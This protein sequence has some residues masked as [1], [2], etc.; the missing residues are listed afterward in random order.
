MAAPNRLIQNQN[1]GISTLPNSTTPANQASNILD[2]LFEQ[3]KI[4][5][6]QLSQTKFES[7]NTGK[8]FEQLAVEKGFIDENDIARLKAERFNIPFVDVTSLTISAELLQKIPQDIARKN[9][10]VAIEETPQGIK[11]AMSDPLDIQKVKFIQTLIGRSIIPVFASEVGL[12]GVIDTRYG[13]Q[14]GAEVA[15]ALEEVEGVV[16]IKMTSTSDELAQDISNAPVSKIVNMIL[17]YAFKFKASDIHIEPREEKLSVRYRVNGVLSEK[18]T[19]PRKLTPSIISRIKILADLKI[20]EH[21]IPQDGRFQ[22]KV[23]TNLI[24]IRVSIVP[25]VYGEKVVMRLLERGG[26]AIPLEKSGLRGSG[27]KVYTEAIRKTQGIILIT[28]PTGSGKTQTLASTLNI[29]NRPEVNIM[30]LEDPVEIRISGVN[31]VQI[32]PD[33]G[34][35]FAKGLRAFLRQDPNIIMVGEIRDGETA[36]LAIQASLTGHLVLATLHT[37]SAAGALP[38]LFDMEIPPYL[39]ASTINVVVGQR[40]IRK[41]CEHCKE[42]YIATPEMMAQVQQVLGNIQDYNAMQAVGDPNQLE[43]F[44]GKG[45]PQCNNTGYSGRSGIFEVMN[46]SENIGRLVMSKKSSTDIQKQAIDEGMITMLQDGFMK[47]IE[48]ITTLEEVIRVQN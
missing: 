42:A 31:Q 16:D 44:R 7:I 39:L 12:Q 25:T 13:A 43:L 15:E 28:G 9:L 30:T 23:D 10:A 6:N 21:R 4:D 26:G 17:E 5:A 19:L 29:L 27:F 37:N 14:V 38:R 40:L 36:D 22:L 48:G 34:L 18:L 8:T 11:V 32:N 46:V 47:A 35:T 41:I 24:D 2:M 1:S 33:V 20:D 45:C 3:G